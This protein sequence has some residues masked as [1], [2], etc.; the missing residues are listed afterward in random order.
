MSFLLDTNI[1][2]AHLRRPA[3]LA[4]RFIQYSGRLSIASLVLAELYAGAYHLPDPAPLLAKIQDLLTDLRVLPFDADCAEQF[5]KIRGSMLRQGVG[6]ST[7]DLMIA[8]IALVHDLT[9][10]THNTADFQNVPNLRLQD[11]LSP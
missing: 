10:V 5:G 1:C 11:W 4:H 3:G 8:S 6:F 2:I 7:V 9:V